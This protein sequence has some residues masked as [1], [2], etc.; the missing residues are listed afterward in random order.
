MDILKRILAKAKKFAFK[1]KSFNLRK[2][3]KEVSIEDAK[4]GLL[5][6]NEMA[7]LHETISSLSPKGMED[8]KNGKKI[9]I[10][11]PIADTTIPSDI[12]AT[13]ILDTGIPTYT[14]DNAGLIVEELLRDRNLLATLIKY[15]NDSIYDLQQASDTKEKA[16][17]YLQSEKG[18]K[19][20]DAN[21]FVKALLENSKDFLEDSTESY[22]EKEKVREERIL[23]PN[24]PQFLVDKLGNAEKGNISS[25]MYLKMSRFWE[26]AG[27]GKVNAGEVF[28]WVVNR[29]LASPG[30]NANYSE[31]SNVKNKDYR[32]AYFFANPDDFPIEKFQNPNDPK[33]VSLQNL[34][35]EHGFDS[36]GDWKADILPS[37]NKR[38][39]PKV[40]DFT[41]K[42]M[43]IIG[44]EL[45]AKIGE[46]IEKNP[47]KV[48]EWAMHGHGNF[49]N[50]N[51][52]FSNIYDN[53]GRSELETTMPTRDLSVEDQIDIRD[54]AI[55]EGLDVD[56][57]LAK[58]RPQAERLQ[59]GKENEVYLAKEQQENEAN[60]QPLIQLFTN[61]YLQ[62]V[63]KETQNLGQDIAQAMLDKSRKV[64]NPTKKKDL[65]DI[66]DRLLVYINTAVK[67]IDKFFNLDNNIE[68]KF[69][70]KSNIKSGEKFYSYQHPADRH[71]KIDI[72][73][74]ALV[75]LGKKL[76]EVTNRKFNEHIVEGQP[77][78]EASAV[79]REIART[80]S[81][82]W[83]P[84]WGNW[85]RPHELNKNLQELGETKINIKRV[86]DSYPGA[87]A[88][89][90]RNMLSPI[91]Q[92]R[93]DGSM[94]YDIVLGFIER[95]RDQE[96]EKPSKGVDRSI[97]SNWLYAGQPGVSKDLSGKDR[98]KFL[99]S[100]INDPS[101]SPEERSMWINISKAT[102]GPKEKLATNVVHAI[103]IMEEFME[104]GKY[105]QPAFRAFFNVVK[106]HGKYMKGRESGKSIETHK[107]S[108]DQMYF[109]RIYALTGSTEDLDP[110]T[111]LRLQIGKKNMDIEFEDIKNSPKIEGL[112]SKDVN[113]QD[114]KEEFKAIGDLIELADDYIYI[115]RG[116]HDLDK[117][118]D[119][120]EEKIRLAEKNSRSKIQNKIFEREF[121]GRKKYWLLDQYRGEWMNPDG[122]IKMDPEQQMRKEKSEKKIEQYIKEKKRR[123]ESP[124]FNPR[125]RKDIVKRIKVFQASN[126]HYKNNELMRKAL[127]ELN[128][129]ASSNNIKTIYSMYEKDAV[130]MNRLFDLAK[131]HNSMKLA[132]NYNVVD[133]MID[134]IINKYKNMLEI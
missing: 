45:I 101:L 5:T 80:S 33:V 25:D 122:S 98:K 120:H 127:E 125:A 81:Q 38:R 129:Y 74:E 48:A 69:K 95:T 65:E 91:D 32:A 83:Q 72:P 44:P 22:Q 123:N 27:Q 24:D 26:R 70:L 117:M 55:E 109:H 106:P 16:V 121:G 94:S 76:E 105:S 31:G 23:D 112:S 11:V 34:L 130:M 51:K 61:H 20:V 7:L 89:E 53:E 131:K 64:K 66:S 87:S 102:V 50:R 103:P 28:E 57:A 63:I 2:I 134:V 77:T 19:E 15:K 118:I 90:V 40:S 111:A 6:E 100:K 59:T 54:K 113:L 39:G 52:E 97:N 1:K 14:P 78:A 104:K 58:E 124:K 62:E 13:D 116:Y 46:E 47:K 79:I 84:N 99:E 88:L 85:V 56:Q 9:N 42:L 17:E 92:E 73:K 86:Y 49:L 126:R 35:K 29:N 133:E 93:L 82:Q 21:Y 60:F 68:E 12:P 107:T 4:S 119:N 67:Q 36:A 115:V 37:M 8:F 43:D 30:I 110:L 71:Y 3:A 132:S 128:A 10:G 114:K 75:I 18:F 41:N 108:K 96:I